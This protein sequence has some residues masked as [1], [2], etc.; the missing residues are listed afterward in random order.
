M[1]WQNYELNGD[2]LYF[3]GFSKVIV[4][5]KDVTKGWLMI[6]EKRVKAKW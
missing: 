4:G 1:A 2:T 5:G 6:E 3:K